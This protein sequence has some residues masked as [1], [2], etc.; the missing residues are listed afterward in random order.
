MLV[1]TV[2][3][4]E[5][6]LAEATAD[7]D[8]VVVGGHGKGP[9]SEVFLGSVAAATLRHTPARVVIIPQ[10]MPDRFPARL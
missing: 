3:D 1:A 10:P 4:P 8:L 5:T 6:D 7:A 9:Q 2:G